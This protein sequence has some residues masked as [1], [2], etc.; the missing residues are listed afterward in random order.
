MGEDFPGQKRQQDNLQYSMAGSFFA[1]LVSGFAFHSVKAGCYT[2]LVGLFFTWLINVVQWDYF[3][4]S[5]SSWS[6]GKYLDIT[7]YYDLEARDRIALNQ[8]RGP[9]PKPQRSQITLFGGPALRMTISS[10]PPLP[11]LKGKKW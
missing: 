10:R 4:A 1:A 7:G 6:E 11:E 2:Y 3:F 9:M 5:P 8:A